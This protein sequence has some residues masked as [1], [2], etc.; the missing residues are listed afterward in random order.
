M[1]YLNVFSLKE[2]YMTTHES[3]CV[4]CGSR[5]TLYPE[6]FNSG[7]CSDRCERDMMRKDSR[8]PRY[9]LEER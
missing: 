6:D 2:D 5:Y 1:D 8:N 3:I 4:N 7:C 9:D